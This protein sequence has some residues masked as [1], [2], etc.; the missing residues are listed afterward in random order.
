MKKKIAAVAVV[1]VMVM[2]M[3]TGCGAANLN[4]PAMEEGATPV[5]VT[6]SCQAYQDGDKLIVEGECDLMTGTNGTVS[7]YSANGEKLALEK[8]TQTLGE[9]ITYTF[10]IE[11]DWPEKVY[12]FITFD[13]TQSDRQ[14]DDVRAAYGKAMENLQ[15]DNVIWDAKGI[16]VCF[17]S[18]EITITK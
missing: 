2:L 9:K 11:D 15:G 6:G 14:P 8:I 12:G 16:A 5:T 7:V 1:T 3:L 18:E 13:T 10:N 17:Q 4:R